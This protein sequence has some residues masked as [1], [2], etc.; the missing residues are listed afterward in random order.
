MKEFDPIASI[1]RFYDAE[2]AFFEASNDNRD[3]H[4]L[5]NELDPEIVVEVPD[6]LP[7]GGTWVGHAGFEDLFGVVA[8]HW[9]QF[10][11]VWDDAHFYR[12]GAD[13]IMCEGVLRGVLRASGNRVEMPV[14]S[15]FTFTPRGASRLVHYYKDTAA[16]VLAGH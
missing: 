10:V 12:I 5:L 14:V 8:T 16:I 3:I 13:R 11:V 4:R 1:R 7:H 15:L 2:N 6:S 9:D